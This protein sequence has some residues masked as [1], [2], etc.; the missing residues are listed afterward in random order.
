VHARIAAELLEHCKLL[1]VEIKSR[2]GSALW[3]LTTD[4]R[5][6]ATGIYAA[7]WNKVA[8][9]CSLPSGHSQVDATKKMRQ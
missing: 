5:K 9:G 4:M 6:D 3:D 1:K 7:A 2:T 8:P